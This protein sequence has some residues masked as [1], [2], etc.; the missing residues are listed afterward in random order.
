MNHFDNMHQTAMY[1]L[2]SQYDGEIRVLYSTTV[3]PS[4]TSKK[5]GNR[6]LP[7]RPGESLEVI[8]NTDDT[9]V[10]CRNDEGKCKSPLTLHQRLSTLFTS[11]HSYA[12]Y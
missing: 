9:K 10:L 1:F 12:N 2:F 8:Q 7:V 3:A 6:D 4:L 5:W 11:W